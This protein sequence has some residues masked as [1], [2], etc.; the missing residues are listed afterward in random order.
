MTGSTSIYEL[1]AKIEARFNTDPL[2]H[3]NLNRTRKK[4]KNL[5]VNIKSVHNHFFIVENSDNGYIA[6]Y[7]I[8]FGELLTKE[9]EI[10]EL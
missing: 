3:I 4:L 6:R 7:T 5:P 1:K 2:I 9:I 8:Q 10:L